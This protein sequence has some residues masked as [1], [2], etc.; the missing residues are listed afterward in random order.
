MNKIQKGA[1]FD[2]TTNKQKQA[3]KKI[4]KKIC[5]SKEVQKRILTKDLKE[6]Y[7]QKK[8]RKIFLI[9]LSRSCNHPV[10]MKGEKMLVES[11]EKEVKI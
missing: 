4:L 8:D 6:F 5:K 2:L 1:S 9:N 11:L 7:K 10:T 3:G